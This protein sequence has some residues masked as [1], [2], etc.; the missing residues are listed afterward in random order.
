MKEF[1]AENLTFLFSNFASVAQSDHLERN[2]GG[3]PGLGLF[4]LFWIV[5]KY[6]N[7]NYIIINIL[8]GL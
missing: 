6:L 2:A 7:I 1:V 4:L 3:N 8:S 5:L